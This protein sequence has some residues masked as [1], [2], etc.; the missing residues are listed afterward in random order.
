MGRSYFLSFH[1]LN[2][3]ASDIL[4]VNNVNTLFIKSQRETIAVTMHSDSKNLQLEY[5]E[6]KNTTFNVSVEHE[7]SCRALHWQV[8]LHLKCDC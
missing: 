7:F 1:E 3:L 2:K 4:H 5:D 8:I 6:E